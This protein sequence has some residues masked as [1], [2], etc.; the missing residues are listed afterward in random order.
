MPCAK[1]RAS[2]HDYP[3]CRRSADLHPEDGHE[4][5]QRGQGLP[6][7][8]HLKHHPQFSTT[9]FVHVKKAERPAE[10]ST[11]KE[12][13][14]KPAQGEAGRVHKPVHSDI[15]RRHG[16]FKASQYRISF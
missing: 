4:E 12:I 16:S 13:R 6:I 1:R 5:A 3:F 9:S 14:I 7:L 2:N 8:N 11:G 10:E 15:L